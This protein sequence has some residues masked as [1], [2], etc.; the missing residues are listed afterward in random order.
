MIIKK[1]SVSIKNISVG[2]HD[3]IYG[4]GNDNKIY[5]WHVGRG[6]WFFIGPEKDE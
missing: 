1:D 6:E 3:N 4:L 2:D 5:I